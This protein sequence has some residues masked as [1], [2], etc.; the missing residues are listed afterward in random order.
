MM[1]CYTMLYYMML[2]YNILY[3]TIR[4]YSKECYVY[5][6]GGAITAAGVEEAAGENT[7]SNYHSNI[8]FLSG[9]PNYMYRPSG[10]LDWDLNGYERTHKSSDI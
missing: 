5:M 9:R 3:Y 6:H 10:A 7:R 8:C 1:L 4:Y 2:Y